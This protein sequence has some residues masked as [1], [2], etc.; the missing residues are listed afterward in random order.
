MRRS[1]PPAL[2]ALLALLILMPSTLPVAVLKPLVRDRFA[3]TEFETALFMAIQMIGA[4]VAAPLAGA[5]SD[6]L[7]RRKALVV[8]ALLL[9]ALAIETLAQPIP[10]GVFLAVRF[11]DGATHVTALSLLMALAV[12]AAPQ[13][14]RGRTLGLLG[15]GLTLGVALGASLG[16]QIGRADALLPLH[17][18][19]AIAA[20]AALLAALALFEVPVRSGRPRLREALAAVVRERALLAPIAFAGVDRFT[21]GFYTA[22][23]PLWLPEVHGLPPARVGMLLGAFLLPFA[24]LSYPFGRLAER[25]SRTAFLCWGSVLY[26][27]G[28]ATL[29]LW[30][31]G[32]LWWPMVFLGVCSAVMF[33]PSMVVTADIAGPLWK[34]AAMGAFNAAGSLGFILGPLVGGAVVHALGGGDRGYGVA[35]AVAGVSELLCVAL[36]LPL[37][38]RLVRAGRTT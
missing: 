31:P 21:V 26:G 23:F 38:L 4:F 20:G 33:V 1:I 30:A 7:G 35:F 11:C 18:G 32:W 28:T 22:L 3:V 16:G 19:A 14:R 27:V 37:L 5:L 34:G 15:G 13:Q 36:A 8:G 17:V 2:L 10:F 12:D 29:G 24:L 9:N 25:R 6:R